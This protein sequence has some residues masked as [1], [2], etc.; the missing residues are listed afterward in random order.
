[1]SSL[2]TG[3]NSTSNVPGGPDQ[4]PIHGLFT[5]QLPELRVD[6]LA[7]AKINARFAAPVVD[8]RDA[9]LATDLEGLQQ[10]DHA[11]VLERAAEAASGDCSA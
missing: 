10:I 9:A 11:H 4:R 3:Q 7:V 1:M 2:D 5:A 6:H 8:A